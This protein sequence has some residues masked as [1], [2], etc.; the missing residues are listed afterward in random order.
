MHRFGISLSVFGVVVTGAFGGVAGGHGL[1]LIWFVVSVAVAVAVVLVVC[2][3]GPTLGPTFNP[4]G[5]VVCRVTR[6]P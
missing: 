5:G 4:M 2:P 6:A 1:Y 3:T